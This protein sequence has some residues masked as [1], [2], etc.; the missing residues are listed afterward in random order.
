MKNFEPSKP[1]IENLF[2]NIFFLFF[3]ILIGYAIYEFQYRDFV[4]WFKRGDLAK[5]AD[6]EIYCY[7]K[8]IGKWHFWNDVKLKA[9]AYYNLGIA[10]YE[11]KE[12]DREIENYNRALELNSEYEEAYFNRANAFASQGQYDQAILDYSK[13]LEIFPQDSDSYFNRG[14]AYFLKGDEKKAL[15]DYKKAVKIN[16]AYL[17]FSYKK[18]S[19]FAGSKTRK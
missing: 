4:Y 13:T 17:P 5:T 9:A 18:N 7:N 2:K 10:Y 12:L 14:Y 6:E 1:K 19:K 8:A 16:P 15:E 3:F 11:K